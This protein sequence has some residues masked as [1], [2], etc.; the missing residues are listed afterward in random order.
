M[1]KL[2]DRNIRISV[3]NLVEFVLRSGNLDNRRS[4]SAE[5]DAMLEGARIHRK[6]QKQ[7][8]SGYESEV[9]LKITIPAEQIQITVEGRAD[10]ILKETEG[11]TIDEIK[12]I[13]QSLDERNEPVTV[14]QAQAICY[15]YIY[16]VQN[17]LEGVYIQL[18]YV[19][20]ETEEIKRFRE[21]FS[22]EMLKKRFDSY[23]QAYA[24]WGL[25]LYHHRLKRAKSIQGLEFPF[26]YRSGQRELVVSVY[27]T[28]VRRKTLFIQAPTGIGK[29][30]SVTFPAV[31]AIGERL[32]DKIFY[33]TAKTI[34]RQAAE[35][36]FQIMREEG[37]H[38]SSVTI[39]AKE[40]LCAAEKMECNPIAC[41]RARGHFD[42]V[43]GAVFDLISHE[44]EASREV[45]LEYAKKHQV[46]PFEMCLDVTYWMDAVICDYNYVF[47]PNIKLQRYFADGVQG[48][49]IFLVDEAHNLVERGREMYS[50]ALI[51]EHVLEAKKRY[52]SYLTLIKKLDRCNNAFLTLKRECD[53]YSVLLEEEGLK[54]LVLALNV[55]YTELQ[56]F[57]EIHPEYVETKEDGEFFFAVRDFLNIYERIDENY[58]IYTQ[59]LE[60]GSFMV[61]L[62]CVNPALALRECFS[63]GV[64]TVFFSA[65]MLPI[66]YYKELLSGE[67][68][69]YAIYARSPFDEQKRL[70]CIGNDV[71]SRYKKRT[72]DE[73]KK[74]AEYIEKVLVSRTGNYL[75]FFPSYR[76]LL[77]VLE[78]IRQNPVPYDCLVQQS[79]MTE[80][81][82]EEF[83]EAFAAENEKGMVG[84]CVVGGI[85]S[86]GIDLKRERLIGVIM[87]GTGLPQICPEREILR[88][89]YEEK[90]QDGFAFAYRYPGMN[91]VLQA[92][93]R[94]IRTDEDYG[95]I[96]LL[97]DRFLQKEYIQQFPLEWS[98][99]QV[100]R[101]GRIETMLRSFWQNQ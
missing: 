63:L 85:F 52:K 11:V 78:V 42:R 14:H 90:G 20:I 58:R 5:R 36:S 65:T 79:H 31:K 3:R 12:G 41:E 35:E 50:A 69:D 77:E 4:V 33:L 66:R 95:V 37:L 71:S 22:M 88:E 8:G 91:K 39:T 19:N 93:G 48:D 40:K 84:F 49:Y 67:Q 56:K 83:L 57:R 26:P 38:L 80:V 27:R 64:G 92:A 18:T 82:R 81:Q 32:A 100:T 29:T 86:E 59:H 46:C 6:I 68:Q 60:D 15:G 16:A 1:H 7:M 23:I 96:L 74:I 13:Y 17:G 87:V 62:F 98:D 9:G 2:V 53:T 43:N 94:L 76:Y 72:R 54:P 21:F 25:F 44:K 47:D 70:L 10:G 24:R 75:V 45:I 89:F 73:F 28:I 55:L 99:Y 30:L 34:T 61:K 51:K 97:D 101:L